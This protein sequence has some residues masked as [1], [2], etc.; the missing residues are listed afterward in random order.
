MGV[1]VLLYWEFRV[2]KMECGF[3]FTL[4]TLTFSL[5]PFF[6]MIFL[7]YV[8]GFLVRSFWFEVT[9]DIEAK[10]MTHVV[11]CSF[12]LLCMFLLHFGNWESRG[13]I[14]VLCVFCMTELCWL[15]FL[16][17]FLWNQACFIASVLTVIHIYLIFFFHILFLEVFSSHILCFRWF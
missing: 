1:L 9:V 14:W 17:I 3:C 5:L 10:E 2:L 15:H 7:F 13:S 12:I 4:R 11:L 6:C 16:P 8:C